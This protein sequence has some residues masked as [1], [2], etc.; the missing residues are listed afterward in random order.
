M[1]FALP[2]RSPKRPLHDHWWWAA[3]ALWA[4]NDH[5]FKGSGFLPGALTGKLS[6]VC[7][8]WVLPA[9]LSAL[10]TR[11]GATPGYASRFAP[12]LLVGFYFAGLQLWPP[13]LEASHTILAALGIPSRITADLSDLWAL[14]VLA[15]AWLRYEQHCTP[16]PLPRLRLAIPSYALLLLTTVATSR[17]DQPGGV[18]RTG[19]LFLYNNTSQEQQ[20]TIRQIRDDVD[21]N[22]FFIQNSPSTHL[23]DALFEPVETVLVRPQGLVALDARAQTNLQSDLADDPNA[24]EA[25]V[26]SGPNRDPQLVFWRSE[27]FPLQSFNDVPANLKINGVIALEPQ[28]A[29]DNKRLGYRHLGTRTIVYPTQPKAPEMASPECSPRDPRADLGWGQP[30]PKGPHKV[31]RIKPGKDGCL[32]LELGNTKDERLKTRRYL[33]IP[34]ERFPF[35]EG[36]IVQFRSLQGESAVIG[37]NIEGWRIAPPEDEPNL[38]FWVI[39]GQGLPQLGKL[40]F[41]ARVQDACSYA[42]TQEDCLTLS[43]PVDIFARSEKDNTEVVLQARGDKSQQKLADTEG[44]W[45]LELL[46]SEERS[47]F[48]GSCSGERVRTG[49]EI[50]LLATWRRNAL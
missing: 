48:D 25:M 19:R 5:W 36:T 22:C 50:Q 44:E 30:F 1:P 32:E 4:L 23:N 40:T 6:D 47:V 49:R 12:Y 3:L 26:L 11:W 17:V 20:V 7:G 14:A 28:G 35:E 41:G 2:T 16:A 29:T 8:L 34:P 38:E 43:R 21:A 39:L 31:L 9:A 15:P 27:E 46:E 42:P 24:C 33:C 13:L 18:Q 10:G 37:D 45:T